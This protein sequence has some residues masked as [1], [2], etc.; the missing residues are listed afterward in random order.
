MVRAKHSA[1]ELTALGNS[2]DDHPRNT[3]T[4]AFHTFPVPEGLTPDIPAASY[5]TDA[6]A[7][8]IAQAAR[9]LVQLRNRWLNPPEWVEWIDEPAPNYPKRP[10]PTAAAPLLQ[11]KRR[12]LTNLYNDRPQ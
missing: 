11:L 5:A 6:R 10:M 7:I 8:A 2:L 3:P 12:T 9:C 4:T 1:G